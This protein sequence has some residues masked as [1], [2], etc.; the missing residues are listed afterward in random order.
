M[1]SFLNSFTE[2]TILVFIMHSGTVTEKCIELILMHLLL[3]FSYTVLVYMSG[4]V[5]VVMMMFW[6]LWC[7]CVWWSNRPVF[8]QRTLWDGICTHYIYIFEELIWLT[9]ERQGE[10]ISI[11]RMSKLQGRL[12]GY[13]MFFGDYLLYSMK[14]DFHLL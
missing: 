1:P 9:I 10:G 7:V 14:L 3:A 13:W 11:R 4:F 12:W 6:F 5:P 2:E 8:L